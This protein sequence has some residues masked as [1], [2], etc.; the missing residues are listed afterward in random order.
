MLKKI[1]KIIKLFQ[2]NKNEDYSD[3]DLWGNN[4]NNE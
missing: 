2:F 3:V 4:E 1:K